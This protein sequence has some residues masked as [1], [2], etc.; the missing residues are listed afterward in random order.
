MRRTRNGGNSVYEAR[1][2]AA[3]AT[4]SLLYM[5]KGNKIVLPPTALGKLANLE[6][7]WPMLFKVSNANLPDVQT[8]CGVLEFTAT[9]GCCVLPEWLH[10]RLCLEEG[11]HVLVTN[12]SLSKGSYVKLRPCSVKFLDLYNPRVV[13]EQSLRHFA[14]LTEG[15]TLTI[16]HGDDFYKIEVLECRPN[17]AISIIETDV[18][19]DFAMPRDYVEPPKVATASSAASVANSD[20]ST[21][22]CPSPWKYRIPGGVRRSCEKYEKLVSEGKIPGLVGKGRVIENREFLG[23]GRSLKNN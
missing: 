13:L 22:L 16:S 6:V 2:V 14:T 1:F 17:P 18:Q 23:V 10:R 19:V 21:N 9:E 12:V 3:L 20:S 11:D 15:D 7:E 8:H 4:G 5:E